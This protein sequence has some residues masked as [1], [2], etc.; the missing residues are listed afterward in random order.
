MAVTRAVRTAANAPSAD[1]V[2]P[3]HQ[4]LEVGDF[5]PDGPPETGCGFIVREV[6]PEALLVLFSTSHVPLSW[7]V[8]GLA[9]I[10]WTWSFVLTGHP[11]GDLHAA[12]R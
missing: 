3:E 10:S 9:G 5:I 4:H 2:L 8:R 6:R 1:R 12:V 7:R 11:R